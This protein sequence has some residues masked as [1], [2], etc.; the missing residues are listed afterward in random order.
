MPGKRKIGVLKD[1]KEIK[2]KEM[3]SVAPW[4]MTPI[5]RVL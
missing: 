5:Y 1:W 2:W 3:L 4:A